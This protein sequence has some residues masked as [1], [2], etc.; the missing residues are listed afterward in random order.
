M[1]SPVIPAPKFLKT[2]P[3]FALAWVL[4]NKTITSAISGTTSLE[5]LKENVAA[6]E[7]K[8]SEEEL[9][10]CDEVWKVFRPPRYSYFKTVAETSA[11]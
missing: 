4:N 9:K 8:L 10:V 1:L 2:L 7:I 6:T 11:Q 3:Q 5:Q